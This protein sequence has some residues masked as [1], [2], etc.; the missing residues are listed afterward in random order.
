MSVVPLNEPLAAYTDEDISEFVSYDIK[1]LYFYPFHF[2][3][4]LICLNIL[5]GIFHWWIIC[6]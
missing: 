2:Q 6:C 5:L 3:Q 4:F 1:R